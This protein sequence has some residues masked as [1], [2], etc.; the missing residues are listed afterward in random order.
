MSE[1]TSWVIYISLALCIA[2]L[3]VLAFMLQEM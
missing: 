3:L 2:G 1:L